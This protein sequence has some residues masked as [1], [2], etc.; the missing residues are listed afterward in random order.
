[1]KNQIQRMSV[2]LTLKERKTFKKSRPL[3]NML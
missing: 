3:E 2:V 1:M